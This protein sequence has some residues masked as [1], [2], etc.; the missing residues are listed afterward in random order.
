MLNIFKTFSPLYPFFLTHL[1]RV[2][3]LTA[4]QKVPFS[5]KKSQ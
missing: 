3:P 1:S 4:L 5:W 2:C